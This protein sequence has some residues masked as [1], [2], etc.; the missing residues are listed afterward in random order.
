MNMHGFLGPPLAVAVAHRRATMVAG[1]EARRGGCSDTGV[2]TL[3]LPVES[4]L[5]I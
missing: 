4:A 1:E 3:E 5:D 2:V